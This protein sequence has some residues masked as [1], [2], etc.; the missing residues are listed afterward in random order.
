M[1]FGIVLEHGHGHLD[2][3]VDQTLVFGP[4]TPQNDC[5]ANEDQV[6]RGVEGQPAEQRT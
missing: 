4:L 1:S 5:G 3:R 6:E 2:K